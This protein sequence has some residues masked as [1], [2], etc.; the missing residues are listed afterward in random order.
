MKG[1]TVKGLVDAIH[2]FNFLLADAVVLYFHCPA[3]GW[4]IGKKR[5]L[6]E[7]KIAQTLGVNMCLL[8][9]QNCPKCSVIVL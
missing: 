8:M 4:W 9:Y 7:P 3:V 6:K 5:T 1:H 2:I